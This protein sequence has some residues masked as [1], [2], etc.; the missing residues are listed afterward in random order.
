MPRTLSRA[1]DAKLE[2]R[3]RE[4][5]EGTEKGR[6]RK[7][8]SEAGGPREGDERGRQRT[9]TGESWGAGAQ[10]TGEGAHDI[11]PHSAKSRCLLGECSAPQW[12]D[13]QQGPGSWVTL[14]KWLNLSEPLLV[15]I[16][17]RVR[18]PCPT[19]LGIHL[20]FHLWAAPPVG[21]SGYWLE[22]PSWP[23]A[24]GN[25]LLSCS[26]FSSPSNRL[27]PLTMPVL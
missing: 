18:S 2:M 23:R 25:S 14:S 5:G 22:S 9:G 6:Q 26:M 24:R 13:S 8:E 3:R 19:L 4:W 20:P 15:L 17:G 16:P 7:W 21:R 12:P 11:T 27:W 10:G 1:P